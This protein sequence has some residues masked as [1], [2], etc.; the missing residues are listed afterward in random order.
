MF[1]NV[2]SL[3]PTVALQISGWLIKPP[4]CWCSEEWWEWQIVFTSFPCGGNFYNG[5]FSIIYV[6]CVWDTL[7]YNAVDFCK[8][9]ENFR[10]TDLHV[11]QL[12]IADWWQDPKTQQHLPTLQDWNFGFI[13]FISQK[14]NNKALKYPLCMSVLT[15][16]LILSLLEKSE[17]LTPGCVGLEYPDRVSWWFRALW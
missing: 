15:C 13:I 16:D 9:W 12:I 6:Y 3:S 5:E 2:S 11:S 10:S 4:G 14:T 8:Y 1:T 7:R 17:N